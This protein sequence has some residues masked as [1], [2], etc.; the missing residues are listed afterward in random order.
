MKNGKR[1]DGVPTKPTKPNP[2]AAPCTAIPAWEETDDGFECADDVQMQFAFACEFLCGFDLP[3]FDLWARAL[4]ECGLKQEMME[5]RE[6]AHQALANNN[7]DAAFRHLE[8]MTNRRREDQRE[9]FLLPLAQRDKKRQDGTQK[10]RRPEITEW[11]NK[12]LKSN[13]SAKSPDLWDSAPEWL[14]EQIGFERFSKRVTKA[15]KA[16]ADANK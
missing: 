14:T 15:R 13:P 1:E 2:T 5:R 11:I 3:R 4:P 9:Q 10:E 8:W 6:L 7:L 16:K 12:K